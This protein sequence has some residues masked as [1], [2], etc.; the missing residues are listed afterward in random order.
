MTQKQYHAR[1]LPRS[2]KT[3]YRD[4]EILRQ[5]TKMSFCGDAGVYG[6]IPA[7]VGVCPH[8]AGAWRWDQR[9]TFSLWQAQRRRRVLAGQ[10]GQFAS[11]EDAQSAAG[12]AARDRLADGQASTGGGLISCCLP[13]AKRIASLSVHKHV[14]DL[15][16]TMP[17][18]CVPGGNAGDSAAWSQSEQGLYLGEYQSRPVHTEKTGIIHMPRSRNG[19]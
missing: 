17:S 1:K 3:E 7:A 14:D 16:A 4:A 5:L 6:V 12:Q 15:C 13:A 11:D 10:P 2:A 8:P 19:E 18:L 9:V